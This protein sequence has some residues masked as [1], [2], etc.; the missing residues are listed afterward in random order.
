MVFRYPHL[1]GEFAVNR[2]EKVLKESAKAD[3]VQA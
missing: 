1:T 2:S 3:F